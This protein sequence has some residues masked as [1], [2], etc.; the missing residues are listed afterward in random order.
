MPRR[1]H[2]ALVLVAL[3]AACAPGAELPAFY[4]APS[5]SDTAPGTLAQ[6]FRTVERAR[7]AVRELRRRAAGVLTATIRLRG[8]LYEL[9]DTLTFGPEDS[10]TI[11]EA[12]PGERPVLSGGR[13]LTGWKVTNGH[14]TLDL[15][16]VRDG[17]GA[18]TQL[19]VNGQRRYRPRLPKQGYYYTTGKVDPSPAA[20]GKGYDRFQ[21]REGD[22]K[23]E[24]AGRDV[25]LLTF[26]TWTMDRTLLAEADG[27][28][29]TARR[30]APTLG[31][32]WFFNLE[33]GTRYLLDN[34]PD[35][36]DTPG[37][38]YLDAQ[39]GRLTYLPLPGETPQKTVVIAPR[40]ETIARLKGDTELGLGVEELVFRGLT[41]AYSG[42][43]M[44]P[45]GN[46]FGQ[47]EVGLGGAVTARGARRC[48]WEDCTIS[49]T[50][51]YG[52]E[53]SNGCH[54]N[55]VTGCEITDLGA[56][57]VKIGEQAKAA[58][59]AGQSSGNV[60]ENCLIAHGG[61][62]HPAG[63]GVWVGHAFGNR[64]IH[65]EI[66]DFYYSG[67]SIGWSWGYGASGA[68]D[69]LIEGNLVH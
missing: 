52:I 4:V 67:L 20:A 40:L 65:N 42:W 47:A 30:S 60:V 45:E 39:A 9:P 43:A 23:P 53:L 56:G 29:R 50:G 62:L 21:Y 10:N 38:W 57:G 8:G 11:Y 41:F 16:D 12:Q 33:K 26:H 46:R 37:Q 19:W 68:H 24:W 5:G 66:A 18:F 49:H 27:D 54:D 64:I 61:R 63:I 55:V 58:D 13:R 1:R 17:K 28:T 7:D 32:I 22:I 31:L 2:A 35:A 6:P 34:V 48:R 69:N 14:W 3:L 36:L 25:E 59:E 15:P 51:M 44:T